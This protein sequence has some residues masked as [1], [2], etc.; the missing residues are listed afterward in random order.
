MDF[1]SLVFPYI[2]LDV[3]WDIQEYSDGAKVQYSTDGGF[4]WSDLGN[5]GEGE[6]WFK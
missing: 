4:S 5:V 1:S 6:N 3:N 2:E